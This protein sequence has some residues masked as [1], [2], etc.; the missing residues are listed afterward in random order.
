MHEIFLYITFNWSWWECDLSSVKFSNTETCFK[1]CLVI[2]H[3]HLDGTDVSIIIILHLLG[4]YDSPTPLCVSVCSKESKVHTHIQYG[5]WLTP[6]LSSSFGWHW[7]ENPYSASL[8]PLDL[9]AWNHHH[10]EL[11]WHPRLLLPFLSGQNLVMAAEGMWH[12]KIWSLDPHNGCC[13]ALSVFPLLQFQRAVYS[14]RVVCV[15]VWR[16]GWRWWCWER[17]I[18]SWVET[19][20]VKW[21]IVQGLLL[22]SEILLV[23][24]GADAAQEE[25]IQCIPPVLWGLSCMGVVLQ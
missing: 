22:G 11:T 12:V 2:L 1:L 18:W 23:V 9:S 5:S 4:C 7:V 6:H 24:N 3:A 13:L 15:R 21:K 25:K 16:W 10:T 8:Q 17:G 20:A 14:G 19:H